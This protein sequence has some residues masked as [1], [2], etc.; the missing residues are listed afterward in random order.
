MLNWDDNKNLQ[1]R[2]AHLGFIQG[3]INRM[4][5]NSFLA[6]G[7]T[8]TLTAAVF[9][10]SDRENDA[11]FILIALLPVAMFWLLDAFFLHEEKLFR[12][13]Y[14]KVASGTISS[15]NFSLDT[16]EVRKE[17][18]SEIQVFFSKT[19]RLYYGTIVGALLFA[20]F[21]LLRR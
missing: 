14:E 20:M 18:G 9:A 8:A 4:G 6:K 5:L 2:I 15:Q 12:K 19:L 3:V 10:L 11:R 7:W 1:A 17:V 16:R 21:A 13:L